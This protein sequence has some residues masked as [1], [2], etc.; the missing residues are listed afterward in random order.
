MRISNGNF[1]DLVGQRMR[2]WQVRQGLPEVRAVRTGQ[3][4]PVVTLSRELGSGGNEVAQALCNHLGWDLWDREL[5]E[6]IARSAN[7]RTDV[8][9]SLD[10]HTRSEILAIL[11]ELLG[12]RLQEQG[13]RRHLG[14]VI[15]AVAS[16]GNAVIIGRGANYLLPSALNVRIV[17][18]LKDRVARLSA[19]E[20]ISVEEAER[21][22]LA[23]D[24]ER[25]DFVHN[26]F[27]RDIN[28]PTDYDLV[29]NTGVFRPA[30]AVRLICTALHVR[31]GV[32]MCR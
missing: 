30:D 10:E 32:E 14:E 24:R 16:H 11:R 8:V 13:Y 21:R 3:P 20:G 12:D 2:E 4:M 19:R 7:V 5:V 22:C 9:R 28:T 26:L 27:G 17:A 1:E 15:L 31:F 6:E 25:A 18:P 29:I 23:S